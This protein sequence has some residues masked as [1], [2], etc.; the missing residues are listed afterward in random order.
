MLAIVQLIGTFVADLFKPQRRLEVEKLFF[1]HQPIPVDRASDSTIGRTLK[2]TLCS[3]IAA[4]AGSS[5]P[6]RTAHS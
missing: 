1:R 6:R 5:R 4:N 3:R 2:K